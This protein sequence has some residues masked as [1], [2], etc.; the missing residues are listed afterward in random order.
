MPDPGLIIDRISN[1]GAPKSVMRFFDHNSSPV[2]GS[3]T[4]SSLLLPTVNRRPPARSGVAC[5]P[6]PWSK[7]WFFDAYSYSHSVAPVAASRAMTASRGVQGE[8][9]PSRCETRYM[10]NSRPPETRM[11]ECPAP[12]GRLQISGGPEAGQRSARPVDSA[13]KSRFLPAH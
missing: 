8:P 1:G 6:A 11:E 5:G 7:S 10:V 2:S 13:V 12:R 3:K 9:P 4:C